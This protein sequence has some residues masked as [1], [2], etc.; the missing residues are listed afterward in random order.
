MTETRESPFLDEE[1]WWLELRNFAALLSAWPVSPGH[2]L[3]VPKRI[4]SKVRELTVPERL[5]MTMVISNVQEF[6]DESLAPQG[7]NIGINEGQ[8]AGQTIGHMH[9]HVIPRYVG[10]MDDPSGGVRLVIPERGNYEKRRA[11][12]EPMFSPQTSGIHD[13]LRGRWFR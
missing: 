4:V 8:V 7:F 3:I 5:E 1:R 12:G 6:L 10:D 9:I 11:A 13:L 2:T